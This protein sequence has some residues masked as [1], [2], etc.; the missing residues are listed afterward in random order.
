[1]NSNSASGSEAYY[2][3]VKNSSHPLAG[4]ALAFGKSATGRTNPLQAKMVDA[5]LPPL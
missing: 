5:D 4:N 1:M 3:N 2:N